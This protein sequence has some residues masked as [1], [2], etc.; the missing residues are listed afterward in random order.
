MNVA[1]LLAT[2]ADDRDAT[3]RWGPRLGRDDRL[4]RVL[5]VDRD[6]A[7]L[8]DSHGWRIEVDRFMIPRWRR[9][10]VTKA[11]TTRPALLATKWL[12]GRKLWENLLWTVRSCDPDVVDLRAVHFDHRLV[13]D[14]HTAFPDSTIVSS[15]A[16]EP[17]A[18]VDV[19]W[20]RYDPT[21]KVSIVLPLYNGA[22]YVRESL[23]SCLAQTH[24]ALEVVVVDD[25][26]SDGGSAVVQEVARRDRRVHLLEN[27][28]NLGVAETLNRGFRHA[29]GELLTWTS[30]DNLYAPGAIEALV[31]HLCTWTDADFVYADCTAM[32]EH[33]N[34][35]K[36]VRILPPSSLPIRNPVGACFLY[37]RAVYEAVGD[38]VTRK[39]VEDYDYWIRVFKSGSRMDG[40][41]VAGYHY[42]FHP[43]S[44]TTESSTVKP[45]R[46]QRVAALQREHFGEPSAWMPRVCTASGG[47]RTVGGRHGRRR[48]GRM[49][50]PERY[51]T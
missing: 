27:E 3:A 23:E 19:S 25:A 26:S 16:P 45:T 30:H 11:S 4:F 9:A 17:P 44:L 48:G 24:T 12:G 20:R 31:R 40:C 49:I 47:V 34:T 5:V 28:A 6:K 37:R 21:V 50:F 39:Y 18:A 32:D 38:Y 15:V 8:V 42:R 35:G 33:G 51:S 36:P 29:T 10:L 46:D 22:A 7:P 2:E 13:G 14:L 1:V 41:R 43:A